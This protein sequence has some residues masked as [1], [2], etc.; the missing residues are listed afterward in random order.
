MGCTSQTFE[1]ANYTKVSTHS[2]VN[3]LSHVP[4]N[5]TVRARSLQDPAIQ[6]LILTD[7]TFAIGMNASLKFFLSLVGCVLALSFLFCICRRCVT[8]Q[9]LEHQRFKADQFR[10]EQLREMGKQYYGEASPDMVQI[11]MAS[12]DHGYGSDKIDGESDENV[13]AAAIS[14]RA[15]ARLQDRK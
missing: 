14:S 10:A 4:Q 5:I 1:V 7:G 12:E 8:F 2:A 15:S 13:Q 11:D 9:R 3:A 6:A